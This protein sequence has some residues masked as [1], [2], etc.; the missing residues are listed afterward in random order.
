MD[1]GNTHVNP[2]YLEQVLHLSTSA[3]I[4]AGED[5]YSAK[6][7]KLLSKGARLDPSV[8]E[9]LI[10]HKLAKPLESC[11]AMASTFNDQR[12]QQELDLLLQPEAFGSLFGEA[13]C[14]SIRSVLARLPLRRPGLDLV[15]SL[16][17]Q[18]GQEDVR[19]MLL[20]AIV[21]VSL[22]LEEQL[23]DKD[24][25]ALALAGLLH[26]VGYLYLDPLLRHRDA[27][28]TLPVWRQLIAQPLIAGM[29]LSHIQ[30][31]PASTVQAVREQH[32]RIDG[33]GFPVGAQGA[34][35]PLLS[36]LFA[37]AVLAS[38]LLLEHGHSGW[39]QARIALQLVANEFRPGTVRALMRVIERGQ[40]QLPVPDTDQASLL[41][42]LFAHIAQLQTG[43][44]ELEDRFTSR[45]KEANIWLRRTTQRLYTIQRTF[46]TTGVDAVA[47]GAR[48]DGPE[49]VSE[50][51]L[52]SREIRRRLRDLGKSALLQLP[53]LDP[54]LHD[55]ATP[56][57]ESL[58]N[59]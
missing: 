31:L 15:L 54:A 50:L 26:Q 33:T 35:F 2:H 5:I 57:L 18:S 30:I 42:P 28:R 22:G 13:S 46:S 1:L 40:A 32:E 29:A 49:I 7:V 58:L 45:S 44:L 56:W 37:V 16:L 36:E 47:A 19:A 34:V 25:D 23:Q 51:L 52:I 43:L 3:D 9:R 20:A 48:I 53:A 4:E 59:S 55:A 10:R 27:Q 41:P 38:R 12:L 8:Q 39:Y 24:L 6:G 17:Q 21:A 14:R 11:I